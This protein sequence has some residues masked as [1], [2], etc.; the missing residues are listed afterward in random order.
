[1]FG[2]PD[3]AGVHTGYWAGQGAA[4][5]RGTLTCPLWTELSKDVLQALKVSMNVGMYILATGAALMTSETTTKM[6]TE[7]TIPGHLFICSY[8]CRQWSPFC[9]SI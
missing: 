1:L 3:I 9:P 4:K 6:T 5:I 2:L 8:Q 7:T